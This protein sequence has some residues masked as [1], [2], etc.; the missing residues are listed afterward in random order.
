MNKNFTM[1]E[2]STE[3]D[4]RNCKSSGHVQTLRWR[5]ICSELLTSSE[6]IMY[7]LTYLLLSKINYLCSPFRCTVPST[8][9]S[10]LKNN[11]SLQMLTTKWKNRKVL[12]KYLVLTD[13]LFGHKSAFYCRTWAK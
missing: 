5:S 1:F 11:F 9:V 3:S 8:C 6:Y 12:S 4:E 13:Y 7:Y 10:D 2:K